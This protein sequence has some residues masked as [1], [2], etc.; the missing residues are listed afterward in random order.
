MTE[1]MDNRIETAY[2]ECARITRSSSS[3]FYIGFLALPNELRRAIYATYAFCRLCDDIVDE[4][5]S[6]QDPASEL[7][8]VQVALDNRTVTSY[9]DDPIFVAI[10]HAIERFDLD[11]QYFIDVIDGCRMDIGTNRYETFDELS[12]YCRRV[13]SSVG[14]ICISIFGHQSPSA[15]KYADDLGIAFQ[16]TN[17]LRDVRE[18]YSNGRVYLPRDELREFGVSE[19]EFALDTS[20]ANFRR[21]LRFQVDRARGYYERGERVIPL[22]TRGRQCLELMSGFYSRILDKIGEEDADVLSN[23][24][25]LSTSEKLSMTLGVAWRSAWRTFGRDDQRDGN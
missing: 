6:G 11:K 24:V 22:A 16:L 25:S 10:E 13:A 19:T 1:V 2:R 12:V 9:E 5:A 17:I 23:R 21:M 8:L 15:L 18:D 20:S 3:N 7:D 4:P 14:L